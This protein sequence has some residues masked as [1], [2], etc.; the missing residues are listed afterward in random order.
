[1]VTM[2]LVQWLG[3]GGAPARDV[4]IVVL[5]VREAVIIIV[6]IV[7]VN[8]ECIKCETEGLLLIIGLELP[9]L[10]LYLSSGKEASEAAELHPD[11]R[12]NITSS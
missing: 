4:N 10:Q 12:C 8:I 9:G 6:I 3:G 2:P 11:S 1:M 5:T 7:T